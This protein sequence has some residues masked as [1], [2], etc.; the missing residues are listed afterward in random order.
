VPVVVAPLFGFALG[1]LFAGAAAEDLAK[2]GT[3]LPSRSL[4]VC[5]LFGVLVFA[6]ACG[7]FTAFFPDWSYAYVFDAQKRPLALDLLLVLVD[8]AA[9]P[10]GFVAF[11]ASAAARRT[12]TL[13]RGALVPASVGGLFVLALLPRLRV[14]ATHAQ[15]H[16]DFGTEPVTGSAVGWAL[17]WMTAVV[18]F[19]S[20]FTLHVLRGLSD[21]SN[22]N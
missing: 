14:L 21:A 20:L 9:P 13:A 8:A 15:F 18:A 5:I 3:P 7:Y 12:A 19:A 11:A 17:V 6:P 22:A 4:F 2:T 10:L 1:V 16:G